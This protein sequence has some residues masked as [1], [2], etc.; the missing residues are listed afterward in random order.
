M[1][2]NEFEKLVAKEIINSILNDRSNWETSIM[3]LRR[4]SD[5]FEL[6]VDF[7]DVSIHKPKKYIFK[8]NEIVKNIYPHAKNLK[9]ELIRKREIEESKDNVKEL[10]DFL[11]INTRKNKLEILNKKYDSD[12]ESNKNEEK[13]KKNIWDKINIFKK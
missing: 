11:N 3:G 8:D 1:K 6:S 9:N 4:K 5:K 13:G 7:G 12:N 2:N 10:T